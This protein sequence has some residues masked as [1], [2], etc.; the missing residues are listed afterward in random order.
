MPRTTVNDRAR[1]ARIREREIRRLRLQLA[2]L[3]R[4]SP[5]QLQALQAVAAAAEQNA[6]LA[7]DAVPYAADLRK[8]GVV[9]IVEGKL[10]LS[11]LGKEYLEDLAEG[12]QEQ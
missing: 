6:T 9:R 10:V 5:A 8:M 2:R 12:A 4:I 11:R 3:E 1:K 7:A